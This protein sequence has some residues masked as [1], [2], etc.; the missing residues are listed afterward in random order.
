MCHVSKSSSP[1]V[2][3]YFFFQEIC[4]RR[5][6]IYSKYKIVYSLAPLQD[7]I[8]IRTKKPNSK[9]DEENS[10]PCVAEKINLKTV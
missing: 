8:Y 10:T 9:E 4:S 3:L 7:P 5:H 1:I 6:E 2:N